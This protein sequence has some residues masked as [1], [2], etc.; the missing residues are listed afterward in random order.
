MFLNTESGKTFQ[1]LNLKFRK[2]KATSFSHFYIPP[3]FSRRRRVKVL[4]ACCF[5]REFRQNHV[6]KT[7]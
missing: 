2:N 7:R 1:T 4:K 3:V 6:L 5:L